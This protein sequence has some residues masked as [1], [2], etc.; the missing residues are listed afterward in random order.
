M[1][2]SHARVFGTAGQDSL[3]PIV[4]IALIVAVLTVVLLPRKYGV[5]P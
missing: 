2:P 5:I 1:P 4:L 3:S